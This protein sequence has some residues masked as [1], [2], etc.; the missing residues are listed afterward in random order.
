MNLLDK[1]PNPFIVTETD[2]GFPLPLTSSRAVDTL[3]PILASV[4]HN[5]FIQ[6]LNS[7]RL[8]KFVL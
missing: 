5:A 3:Y 8:L 6:M 4:W 2:N 7:R 1:D